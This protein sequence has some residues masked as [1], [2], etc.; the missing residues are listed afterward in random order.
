MRTIIVFLIIFSTIS[1]FALNLC[2]QITFSEIMYDV[3]TN[4]YHDEFIEIFNLSDQDSIDITGWTFSD[5]SG[6]DNIL[7]HRGGNKIAPRGFAVILD[8][9]YFNN[10]TTYDTL[11]ADSLVILKIE[12]NSFG[13]SGLSNSKAEWLTIRDTTGQVLTEYRYSVGNTPGYSDEKID[14]DGKNDSL[15]WSDTKIEGGTPGRR[16]SVSPP[17]Y[18]FGFE[19]NSLI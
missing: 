15:N 7:P 1:V 5:S 3:A 6:I 13:K 11:L 2:A 17:L 9:S 8:G 18:D 10:S 16:N 12:D 19:E 4:E 14:L